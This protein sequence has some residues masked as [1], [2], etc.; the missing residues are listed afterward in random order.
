[1]ILLYR[2]WKRQEVPVLL[3]HAIRDFL[4]EEDDLE[5]LDRVKDNQVNGPRRAAALRDY[6]KA[7]RDDIAT[8]R[9]RVKKARFREA[10]EKMRQKMIQLKEA[11]LRALTGEDD[12]GGEG[13]EGS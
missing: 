10:Q 1:M 4:K 12:G 5:V 8:E 2:Y 6:I 13:V 3:P 7:V 9:D 11:K